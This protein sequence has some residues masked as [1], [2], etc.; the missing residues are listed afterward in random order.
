MI[1]AVVAAAGFA[2]TA[3][4]NPSM[5]VFIKP[6]TEEFGWSRATFAG[7]NTIGTIGGGLL[8]AIAVVTLMG[9]KVQRVPAQP[10]G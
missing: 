4:F 2:Q 7:A 5:G 8:A 10:V 3:L 1:V 6:V 9:L